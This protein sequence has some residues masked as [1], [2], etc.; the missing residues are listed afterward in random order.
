MFSK[1][2]LS[3]LEKKNIE[4][5]TIKMVEGKTYIL[6]KVNHVP[7][8]DDYDDWTDVFAEMHKQDGTGNG[9]PIK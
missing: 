5:G 9:S 4:N 2:K 3:T 7:I 8:R 6:S 1:T